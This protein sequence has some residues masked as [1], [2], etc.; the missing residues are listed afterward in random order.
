MQ[1]TSQIIPFRFDTREVRTLLIEDQ[2][3]FFAVDVC[4][5]L[6]LRDTNKALLGLDDD[7]KREHEQYSG[8]GRKPVLINESGL[9]S[10]VLR[11]RKAEAKRFKK[12][13]TA[14]VLPSIRKYGYYQER[15]NPFADQG[16]YLTHD[17]AQTLYLLLHAVDWVNYRW[18]QGIG[19][20]V[21]A[22]NRPLYGSTCEHVD[23]MARTGRLLDKQLPCIK[24]KFSHLGGRR[25]RY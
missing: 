3:W 13:V 20:G 12:W 14:E 10:L 1:S 11:S 23:N 8:S 24:R 9:Y 25:P 5:A 22:I 21:A 4:S 18:R 15:E 16:I 2:P 6:N 17:Q 19:R 7:E